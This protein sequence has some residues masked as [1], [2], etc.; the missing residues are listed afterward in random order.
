MNIS[1]VGTSET[2]QNFDMGT[3]PIFLEDLSFSQLSHSQSITTHCY[4]TI[5]QFEK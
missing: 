5:T 2:S 4:L 3:L 1:D